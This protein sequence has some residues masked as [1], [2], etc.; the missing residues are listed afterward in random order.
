MHDMYVRVVV[1]VVV[2]VVVHA[3]DGIPV[4]LMN[5]HSA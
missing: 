1:V 5:L 3:D 2:H 4:Q